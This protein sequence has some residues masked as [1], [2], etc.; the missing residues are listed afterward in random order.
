MG[1]YFREAGIV[2]A[3]NNS[4]V[5]C[6]AIAS[7]EKSTE[8]IAARRSRRQRTHSPSLSL[9]CAPEAVAEAER[10]GFLEV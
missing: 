9:A 10:G 1:M 8:G 3:A 2:W 5:G 6:F 7:V 4:S